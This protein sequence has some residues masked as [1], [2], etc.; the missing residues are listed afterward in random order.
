M[1]LHRPNVPMHGMMIIARLEAQCIV[2]TAEG[3][4]LTHELNPNAEFGLKPAVRQIAG[5]RTAILRSQACAKVPSW[6][7]RSV[8]SISSRLFITNGP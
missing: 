1:L 2:F 3:L 4:L 8:C 7:S 5:F 6:I